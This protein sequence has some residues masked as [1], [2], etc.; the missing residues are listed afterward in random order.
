MAGNFLG[1]HHTKESKLKNRLAH[2]GKRHCDESKKK[3]SNSLKGRH[4]STETRQRMSLAQKGRTFLPEAIMKIS[5]TLKEL[6][7]DGEYRKRML[8]A[9]HLNAEVRGQKISKAKKGMVSTF[10]GRKHTE[11][12]KRKNSLA[13]KK[14]CQDPKYRARLL[15]HLK[16]DEMFRARLRGLFKRPTKPEQKLIE[17]LQK[18]GLPFRY[19]GNGKLIMGTIYITSQ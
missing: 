12:A 14:L 11:E 19:V 3:I 17:L 16:S 7:R 4:F 6:W 18:T 10:K 8:E 2:L 5:L 9:H 15:N 1:L 13:H